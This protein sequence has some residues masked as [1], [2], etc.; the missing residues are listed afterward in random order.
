MGKD[1][2]DLSANC[3]KDDDNLENDCWNCT[4]F[5]FPIGCMYYEELGEGES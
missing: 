1:K 4:Y 3:D 2:K 5:C